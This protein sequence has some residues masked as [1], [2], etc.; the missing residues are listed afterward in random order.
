VGGGSA[1][2]GGDGVVFRNR[3]E[4]TKVQLIDNFNYRMGRHGFKVGGN[5]LFGSNANTFWGSGNGSY[6][7][8]SL[9]NFENGVISSYTRSLRACKAAL[10][11]NAAGETVVCPEYDVP[12][13]EFS[14][15]EYAVYGQ[16]EIELTDRLTVTGGLRFQ[17][18]KFPDSPQRQQIVADTFGFR[19]DFL[20]AFTG[21]SPRLSFTYDFAEGE[22]VL[23]GGVAMLVGRAPTVL[24]GN[25]VQTERPLLSISCS[26]TPAAPTLNGATIAEMLSASDGSRNPVACRSGAAPAGRPEFTIFAEDFEL[27]KTLKASIGYEHLFSTSTKIGLDY[28]YSRA[29]DQFTVKDLNLGA[30]SCQPS[31]TAGSFRNRAYESIASCFQLA[32][33]NNRPV[34][35][36]RAGFNPRAVFAGSTTSS[37]NTIA[38]FDR[39]YYN[40]SDG[41]AEAHN[42]TITLDQRIGT[43]FNLGASYGWVRAY[44]NSSFSC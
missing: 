31:Q 23:R 41:E 3:L 40:V 12:I 39:V 21:L 28:V 1:V 2:F 4:E 19:N 42:A 24:A 20:P 38:T 10:V 29:T 36:P 6:S 7:F 14:Y 17:G 43:R 13:G 16:D 25:A 5:V 35:V 33:E 11:A 15:T 32:N 8:T 27:P 22:R 18:T 37:R 44:D 34:F 26:G 30:R 9:T